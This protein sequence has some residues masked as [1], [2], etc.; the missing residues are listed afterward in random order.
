MLKD[1]GHQIKVAVMLLMVLSILT[2]ILYPL[3][4]TAFAQVFFPW[5]ANGS[6]LERDGRPIGSLLIGQSFDSPDYFWGRP[7][8]TQP[9]PYNGEASQGSNS[10]PSNVAFL[11]MVHQRVLH[12]KSLDPLNPLLIPVDLVTASASGLDADISP[13]AAL[14]QVHRIALARHMLDSDLHRLVLRQIKN[15]WLGVLGEPCINVL[16][17]NMALDDFNA[18][19]HHG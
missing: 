4:I 12:L 5:Q 16:Q 17:L 1:M 8:A 10:G 13:A 9:F 18:R 11:A 2:G 14:Y 6:I 3:A 19:A 15:R 7:S